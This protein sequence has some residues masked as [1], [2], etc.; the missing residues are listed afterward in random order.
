MAHSK[1]F[2]ATFMLLFVIACNSNQHKEMHSDADTVRQ[3]KETIAYTCPM[4]H[5]IREEAPGKCP[6]CGMT[7][8]PVE[9][10][11]SNNSSMD[12]AV[13]I[14]LT[15][16]EQQLAG[17]HTDTARLAPL[18]HQLVLTGTTIFNPQHQEV[19]SAWVGGWIEKL[20]VRNPGEMIHT[21]QKLYDLYSPDLLSAEKDYLLAQQQKD[22]FKSASVDFTA[23]IQAMKQKLSR[24]GLTPSQIEGLQKQPPTGRVTI[25]SKSSGY[26]TQK[27]KEEGYHV[28]EGDMVMD[29][30]Q[31]STLWVQAQLYDSELPLI[32]SHPQIWVEI[33]GR[34]G[35]KIPGK[36]VF[37]NPVN[38][39]NS[40]VNLLNI[41]IPNP[42]DAIQPGML[43]YVYLQTGGNQ[44]AVL[45]PKSAVIYDSGQDYVWI[46]RPDSSPAL[47]AG[48]FEMRMV[49]LGSDNNTM[50]EVLSG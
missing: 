16:A 41:A 27:L 9:N 18:D 7:L 26:L 23:T 19:I 22:L 11:S 45:I 37:N 47:P 36:I 30:A 42:G 25:F 17:I 33:E 2:I 49:Q 29:I 21:G 6:I 12:T 46:Q 5:Q 40:R 20:Y 14:V 10:T 39:N 43:A 38:E 44:P 35:E 24:W 31:S 4:H 50:A 15:P 3:K 1:L 34:P 32:A 48:R 28:N 13:S 8:V